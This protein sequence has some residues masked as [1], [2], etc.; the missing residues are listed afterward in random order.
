MWIE[1]SKSGG[2]EIVRRR[3]EKCL[4]FYSVVLMRIEVM[5]DLVIVVFLGL[6]IVFVIY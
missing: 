5:F 6:R 2:R 3:R 1:R 4:V